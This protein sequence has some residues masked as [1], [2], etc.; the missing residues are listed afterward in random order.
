MP[1]GQPFGSLHCKE[2][3]V[4]SAIRSRPVNAAI[5]PNPRS[6]HAEHVK[7]LQAFRVWKC[8]GQEKGLNIGLRS[9]R[10]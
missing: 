1:R 5:H 7:S 3:D 4:H 6:A 10:G 8:A 9:S 2:S